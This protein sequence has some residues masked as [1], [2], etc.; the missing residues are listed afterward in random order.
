MPI[1][2]LVV[3][4]HLDELLAFDPKV[5]KVLGFFEGC[6]PAPYRLNIE[7]LG[8]FVAMLTFAVIVIKVLRQVFRKVDSQPPRVIP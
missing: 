3:G 8:R 5:Q 2:D 4:P 1:I 6:K 7:A